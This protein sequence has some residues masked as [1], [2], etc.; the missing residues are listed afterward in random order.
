[1]NEF[2]E[3]TFDY[4][5]CSIEKTLAELKDVVLENKLQARDIA[6]LKDLIKE[7]TDI[8]DLHEHR[9]R[10]LEI[11]PSIS[12]ASKWEHYVKM[13]MELVFSAAVI[14]ILTKI[15]LK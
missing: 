14:A 5:L 9:I 15:G 6:S 13:F 10:E 11:A 7:N 12:K 3:D 4:R 2:N 1:M 8:I